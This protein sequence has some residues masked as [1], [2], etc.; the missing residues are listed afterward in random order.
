MI[1]KGNLHGD[2]ARLARY[3]MTGEKGEIAELVE[4]RGLECF[5]R[6][7]VEAF[8]TLQLLAAANTKSTKPFFHTQTRNAPG[9][10]LTMEQWLQVADREEKRL[11]FEGQPRIVGF[12]RDPAS[13]EQH[14]HVGWFRIDL[15]TMRARDP[16]LF[17]NH[18]KELSRQFEREFALREVSNDRPPNDG[19]RAPER[20]EAEEA[21]RLKTDLKAIRTTILDCLERSDGG[22]AFQAALG[23]HGLM[24]AHGDRRDCFVVVDPAGGQHALNKRLTGQ[25]LPAIRERLGDLDRAQ[26]PGVEE[27]QEQQRAR[28]A[29]RHRDRQPEEMQPSFASAAA[30]LIEPAAPVFDRDAANAAWMEQVADAAIV[31]EQTA[32]VAPEGRRTPE[33]VEGKEKHGAAARGRYEALRPVEPEADGEARAG[34]EEA[35]PVP[36]TGAHAVEASPAAETRA[37]ERVAGGVLD[38]LSRVVDIVGGFLF[39]WGLA[40]PKLTPQQAELAARANDEKQEARAEQATREEKADAIDWLLFEQNRRAQYDA[41]LKGGPGRDTPREVDRER[42]NDRGLERER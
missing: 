31:K 5:G 19:A 21:R 30:H 34:R 6:D 18:L 17:K 29:E 4:A 39:G 24:L 37:P 10:H 1:A 8:A 35:S 27:A 20:G 25:T 12:H 9:E 3:V 7:P 36:E 40:G 38:H 32:S 33:P 14:L 11:G 15:E 13:G 2:G 28:P 26:L 42:D 41:L 16:G 22:K 23:A